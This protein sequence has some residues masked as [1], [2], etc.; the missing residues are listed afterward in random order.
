[1]FC[2]DY[3]QHFHKFPGDTR[4]SLDVSFHWLSAYLIERELQESQRARSEMS[5]ADLQR[6]AKQVKPYT[7]R[8]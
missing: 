8:G 3:H 7:F 2:T 4:C 6:R 5:E 1:M